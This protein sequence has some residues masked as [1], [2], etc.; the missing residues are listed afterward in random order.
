M[1]Y[2][3]QYLII[4]DKCDLFLETIGADNQGYGK[5]SKQYDNI[6]LSA[7]LKKII[8]RLFL[9]SL[10]NIKRYIVSLLDD[11]DNNLTGIYEG[12][13]ELLVH[14]GKDFMDTYALP[15][16]VKSIYNY[17]DS[18]MLIAYAGTYHIDT[19]IAALAEVYN[20]EIIY[21]T[22]ENRK[23]CVAVPNMDF[24]VDELERLAVN[25]SSCAQSALRK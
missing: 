7:E 21:E 22:E 12:I 19:Y 4:E 13:E 8:L 25:P 24:G 9:V 5:I 20:A 15:R 3:S 10:N 11:I 17:E 2:V 6:P 1:Y 16:I 18:K 23:T 14:I